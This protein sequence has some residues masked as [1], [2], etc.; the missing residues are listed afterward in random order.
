MKK[1]FYTVFLFLLWHFKLLAIEIKEL[2]PIYDIRGDFQNLEIS[3]IYAFVNSSSSV[4]AVNMINRVKEG[5]YEFRK[6]KNTIDFVVTQDKYGYLLHQTGIEVVDFF[7][8]SKPVF[9]ECFKFPSDITSYKFF[10]LISFEKRDMLYLNYGFNPLSSYF[11]PISIARRYEPKLPLYKSRSYFNDYFLNLYILKKDEEGFQVISTADPYSLKTI[12]YYTI[13]DGFRNLNSLKYDDHYAYL[14]YD[15]KLD[16]VDLSSPFDPVLVKSVFFK[17]ALLEAK[18][19]KLFIAEGSKL[20]IEDVKDLNDISVT[21]SKDLKIG[22]IKK[23]RFYNNFVFVLSSEG[24]FIYSPL[25]IPVLKSALDDFIERLYRDILLREPDKNGFEYWKKAFLEGKR[26]RE[27]VRYFFSCPEFEKQNVSDDEFLKRLYNTV[28]S[29]NPD[30]RGYNYWIGELKDNG[31][32]REEVVE[33]F[34]QSEEFKKLA[35]NYGIEP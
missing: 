1:L 9:V 18:D 33:R 17:G 13:K 10:K 11:L 2:Y 4:I 24:L 8:P 35:R 30:V 32:S 16:I 23:V 20:I 28:L 27:V 14:Q 31:I 12:G 25:K 22:R 26:A 5:E 29:R 3:D 7:I 19:D 15:D 21:F 6:C 34:T